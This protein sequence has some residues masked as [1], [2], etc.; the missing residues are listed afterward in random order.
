MRPFPRPRR[1]GGV[2]AVSVAVAALAVLAGC[3]QAE[4]QPIPARSAQKIVKRLDEVQRRIDA[5][6]ACDDIR[7]DSLPAL[8][9]EI[10]RLPKRTDEDVRTTLEDGLG[11]LT[12]L[13]E[14]ECEEPPAP[15][16]EPEPEPV[17]E[18]DP[19]PE[20]PTTP[21]PDPEPTYPDTPQ[22]PDG[23]SDGDGG[24][25]GGGGDD[26][27]GGNDDGRGDGSSGGG[28]SGRGD[29]GDGDTG[30]GA[31]LAPGDGSPGVDS[32]A[33]AEGAVARPVTRGG[34]AA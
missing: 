26:G 8:E 1:S 5:Q 3:G 2:V 29:E 10:G 25:D 22:I 34:G 14:A 11:R 31:G 18:P 19:V 15:E 27:G 28:G 24:N 12:E 6:N 7:E 4:G 9:R 33:A 20:V 30:R 32:D 21:E 23:G 17:P 16:R 13:V